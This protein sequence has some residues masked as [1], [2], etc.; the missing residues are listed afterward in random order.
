VQNT[1]GGVLIEIEGANDALQAFAS[2]LTKD[3]PS[4][5]RIDEININRLEFL[6][7]KDFSILAS[8]SGEALNTLISPDIST[9]DD[10]RRELFNPA[11]HRYLYP[12]INCTNCGPRFTIVEGTPY[13][14]ERTSMRRFVM[15]GRCA[16][17]YRDPANRRFHAEPDACW[18]CGPRVRV[19]SLDA[20]E[21]TL[22]GAEDDRETWIR[23]CQAAFGRG[24]ILAVKGVGGFQLA[25]DVLCEQAVRELRRRKR[26]PGRPFAIMV[27]DV[28]VARR[29][30]VVSPKEQEFLMSQSSPIVILEKRRE[31]PV[32]PLV[33][34]GLDHFGVMLPY[35]PMHA[36]LF[37]EMPGGASSPLALV[38]T[39]GNATGLP[40]V[41]DEEAAQREL[42]PIADRFV[43]HNR[44]I[45]RPCDD[46]V[47]RVAMGS[48]LFYRRSRG[49]VPADF[50]VPEGRLNV[51][52]AGGEG[53]NTFC[54]L[55][56]GRARLSQH[57]GDLHNRESLSRYS[58]LV[59]DFTGLYGFSPDVLAVDMHPDYEVTRAAM[60]EF[61]DVPVV[62]VQHHHAHMVSAMAEA[63]V[64]TKKCKCPR[65]PLG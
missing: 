28:D 54:L 53:K 56:G 20:T 3:A 45:V 39:S 25:C 37:H 13:D 29:W 27:K 23:E 62:R 65:L 58:G 21:H 33:A 46:S 61:P 55:R 24:E 19:Y 11:E 36:L 31:C 22:P 48:P 34:P 6:G 14:R 59:R 40:L 63:G 52:G 60:T 30:F 51:F 43:V 47:L 42:G 12:F 35:T 41:Y 32:T 5:S 10:C 2:R 1:T 17:E 50:P 4:L 7:Y 26:C 16:E 49:Y 57:G 64:S 38:M 18:D 44:P 15:C 8:S 9:C